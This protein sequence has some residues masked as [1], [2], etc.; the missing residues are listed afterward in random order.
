MGTRCPSFEKIPNLLIRICCQEFI[1]CWSGMILKEDTQ[2]SK[3]FQS[4]TSLKGVY[5]QEFWA[6]IQRLCGAHAPRASCH[7]AHFVVWSNSWP[8]KKTSLGSW[9]SGSWF[10]TIPSFLNI[11]QG[12]QRNK[13]KSGQASQASKRLSALSCQGQ[14]LVLLNGLA[15]PGLLAERRP[16]AVANAAILNS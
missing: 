2:N 16:R 7:F 6:R 11:F 13:N 9:E 14:W 1:A 15:A 12:S 4:Q 5:S 10:D 3:L 8:M